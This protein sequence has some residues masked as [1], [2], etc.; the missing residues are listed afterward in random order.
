MQAFEGE[1][2]IVVSSGAGD[3]NSDGDGREHG[4][5]GGEKGGSGG[6][7]VRGSEALFEHGDTFVGED[8]LELSVSEVRVGVRS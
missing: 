4:S 5:G 3:V 8:E 1:G 2:E 7:G 6:E